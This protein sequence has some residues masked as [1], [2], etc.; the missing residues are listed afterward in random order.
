MPNKCVYV[1]LRARVSSMRRRVS[2]KMLK[3]QVNDSDLVHTNTKDTRHFDTWRWGLLNLVAM[4]LPLLLVLLAAVFFGMSLKY[5]CTQTAL[6][7][8]RTHK[9]TVMTT[10]ESNEYKQNSKLLACVV[11]WRRGRIKP[12]D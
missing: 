9:L 10:G 7:S 5:L 2:F 12:F 1:C 4:L 6:S 8:N 3:Y 11:K